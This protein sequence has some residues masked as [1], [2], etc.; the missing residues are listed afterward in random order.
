MQKAANTATGGGGRC[1]GWAGGGGASTHAHK[2]R[3]KNAGSFFSDA[4]PEEM[5]LCVLVRVFVCKLDPLPP[6][7]KRKDEKEQTGKRETKSYSRLFAE[8][9]R[10]KKEIN[11]FVGGAA[12]R[13]QNVRVAEPEPQKRSMVPAAATTAEDRWRNH[14]E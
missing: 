12:A 2:Q 3:R 5:L 13:H 14:G 7:K 1:S 10:K 11:H 8:F 4:D 6:N 9:Q